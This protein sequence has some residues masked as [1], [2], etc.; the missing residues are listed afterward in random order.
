MALLLVRVRLLPLCGFFSS[1]SKV[2]Y[3]RIPSA[4]AKARQEE[5]PPP[6]PPPPPAATTASM[7]PSNAQESNPK[8]PMK[9]GIDDIPPVHIAILYGFQVGYTYTVKTN[10]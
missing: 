5:Q 6:P 4:E 8:H 3:V 7:L 10:I 1:I 9:Y 2:C